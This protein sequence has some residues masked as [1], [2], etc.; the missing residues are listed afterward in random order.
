MK[1]KKLKAMSKVKK[2]KKCKVCTV[3][4]QQF[5]TTDKTCSSFCGVQWAKSKEL[6]KANREAQKDHLLRKK[7]FRANDVKLRKETAQRAFNAFIRLRDK[8]EPC[9]SCDKPKTWAGQWHAG[10]FKTTGARS[11]IRFH[12]DNCHKQCSQ[13]NNHLSGNIGLYTPRLIQKIGE[14]RFLALEVVKSIKYKAE[15]YKK[16]ELI[17]KAKLKELSGIL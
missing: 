17:Y 11:D 14:K 6:I 8:Y 4:F 13:C 2:L 9:I 5:R 7:V 1:P 10:H 3:E 16:I 12:E 15:D